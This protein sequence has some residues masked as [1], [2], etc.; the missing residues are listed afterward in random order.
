VIMYVVRGYFSKYKSKSPGT[1]AF[2]MHNYVWLDA[3]GFDY[4]RRSRQLIFRL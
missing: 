2:E 4:S 3:A 1:N